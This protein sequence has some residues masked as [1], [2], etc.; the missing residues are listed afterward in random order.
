MFYLSTHKIYFKYDI[1]MTNTQPILYFHE[2]KFIK[3][4]TFHQNFQPTSFIENFHPKF[5]TQKFP[6]KTFYPKC[7]QKTFHKYND[8]FISTFLH[9]YYCNT[10][11]QINFRRLSYSPRHCKDKTLLSESAKIMTLKRNNGGDTS[12]YS[13]A[14]PIPSHRKH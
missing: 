3:C 2:F 5:S 4:G 8:E 10:N 1:D 6:P 9:V 7:L 14:W 12:Q 11:K 13:F